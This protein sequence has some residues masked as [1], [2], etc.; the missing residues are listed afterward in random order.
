MTDASEG[1]VNVHVDGRIAEIAL[2]NGPLNLVTRA[3]LRSLNKIIDELEM[4]DD[5]RC[6]IVHGGS[7]RAFCAGSDIKEFVD[8]FADASEKKIL[9]E[10]MV[11]RRLA[12]LSMPTIAAIDGPALG[13]GLELALACDLRVCRAGVAL[14]L[15]EARLGGLAGN[16]S[17]RLTRL[18]GPARAKELLFTGATIDAERALSWG[19]VNRVAAQGSALSAARELAHAICARGPLSNR[20]AKQLVDA[21]LDQPLDAALSFSTVVQQK[22]FDSHDLHEGAAA[23]FAKREPEFLGR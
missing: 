15:T 14:G 6:V 16:G 3:L 11:L 5:L 21:A 4:Q 8:I 18:V 23:F 10:D 17:L 1:A 12:R 22:I 9:F 20:F 7:A 19:L 13:G 2:A